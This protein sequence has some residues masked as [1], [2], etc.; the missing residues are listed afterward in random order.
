[1]QQITLQP[2]TKLINCTWNLIHETTEAIICLYKL[3]SMIGLSS[4]IPFWGVIA[5]LSIICWYFWGLCHFVQLT[6]HNQGQYCFTAL[7]I[8]SKNY[9]GYHI[10]LY[11]NT[12]DEII[13]QLSITTTRCVDTPTPSIV[14]WDFQELSH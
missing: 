11:M 14:E 10:S 9:K 2:S 6:L 3:R 5:T 1:M 7:E 4:N 12:D 8:Q 13:F